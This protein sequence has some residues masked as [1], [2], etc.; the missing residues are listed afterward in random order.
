MMRSCTS[1]LSLSQSLMPSRR[2][3]GVS[4][5]TFHA[6]GMLAFMA[7]GR[8]VAVKKYSLKFIES[9]RADTIHLNLDI[10]TA[11]LKNRLCQK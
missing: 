5:C 10:F 9:W 7:R 2:D 1:I 11:T 6:G 8:T 3:L 4:E